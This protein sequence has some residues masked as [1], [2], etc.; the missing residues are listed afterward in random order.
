MCTLNANMNTNAAIFDEP[1]RRKSG[2][3]EKTTSYGS[4][5]LMY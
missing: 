3:E 2:L 5:S 4:L 1:L